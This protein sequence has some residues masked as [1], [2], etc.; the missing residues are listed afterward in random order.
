[1]KKILFLLGLAV[2]A[3]TSCTND[4]VVDVMQPTQKTIGFETFVNKTTRA[5]GTVDGT[6]LTNFWV[7]ANYGTNANSLTSLYDSSEKVYLDGSVWKNNTVKYW[8][9][10][11]YNFAAYAD[12]NTSDSAPRY[13]KLNQGA[14]Q[15]SDYTLAYALTDAAN[16]DAIVYPSVCNQKD[17]VADVVTIQ[18]AMNYNSKVNF[19]LEHLLSKVRFTVVNNSSYPMSI[20]AL[21]ISGINNKGSISIVQSTE[22]SA[23]PTWTLPADDNDTGYPNE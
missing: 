21:K 8:T 12:D 23:G 3:M 22:L 14:L 13:V 4:E 7:L 17:I 19:T 6:S 2:A 16:N 10:N 5:F 18:G 20:S 1:M 11:V 9:N 15:I